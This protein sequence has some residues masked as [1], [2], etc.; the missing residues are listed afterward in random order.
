[1]VSFQFEILKMKTALFILSTLLFFTLSFASD[2]PYDETETNSDD[3][4]NSDDA[5]GWLEE[6]D[7]SNLIQGRNAMTTL[8]NIILKQLLPTL[9]DINIPLLPLGPKVG[10][11]ADVHILEANNTKVVALVADDDTYSIKNMTLQLNLTIIGSYDLISLQLPGPIYLNGN[12]N[13][14]IDLED[15]ILSI[16][17]KMKMQGSN[18]TVLST[19]D[20]YL[21]VTQSTLNFEHLM[22]NDPVSELLNSIISDALPKLV[23]AVY[24]IVNN[25]AVDA[26]LSPILTYFINCLK[27]HVTNFKVCFQTSNLMLDDI[28]TGNIFDMEMF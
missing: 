10:S 11:L 13:F 19:H 22:G 26:V 24:P 20:F 18:I 15:V 8:F 14:S 25:P 21:Q 4:E 9:K 1:M 27:N 5:M 3:F 7:Y 17:M 16:G 28:L 2:V 6:S 23:E 12:G